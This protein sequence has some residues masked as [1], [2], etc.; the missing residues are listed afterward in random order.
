MLRANVT[1][2]IDFVHWVG[3]LPFETPS[4]RRDLLDMFDLISAG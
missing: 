3:E 4:E 1:Y 2:L